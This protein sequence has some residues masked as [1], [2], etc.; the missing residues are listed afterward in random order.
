SSSGSPKPTMPNAIAATSGHNNRRSPR[1]WLC[2][3][4]FSID[5]GR[6]LSPGAMGPAHAYARKKVKNSE[7]PSRLTGRT[8]RQNAQIDPTSADQFEQAFGRCFD[9]RVERSAGGI[10]DAQ[11]PK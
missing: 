7:T 3:P 11:R 4:G 10:D 1:V 5:A 8:R 9:R 6:M 2:C